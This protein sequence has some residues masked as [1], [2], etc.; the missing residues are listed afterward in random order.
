MANTMTS[1]RHMPFKH[2]KATVMACASCKYGVQFGFCSGKQF[3]PTHPE[4]LEFNLQPAPTTNMSILYFSNCPGSVLTVNMPFSA[5]SP[6]QASPLHPQPYRTVAMMG[7][8]AGGHT[9]QLNLSS[10]RN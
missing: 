3:Q 4:L 8:Y 7:I 2:H 9:C 5:A 6:G 10:Q 1:V